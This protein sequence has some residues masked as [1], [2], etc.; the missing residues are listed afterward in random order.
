MKNGY[1]SRSNSVPN[2]YQDSASYHHHYQQQQQQA[3]YHP[4]ILIPNENSDGGFHYYKEP[5]SEFSN[6]NEATIDTYYQIIHPTLPILPTSK[7]QLK[8]WLASFE[9]KDLAGALLDALTG[10]TLKLSQNVIPSQQAFQLKSALLKSS[11]GNSNNNK[12]TS[13]ASPSPEDEVLLKTVASHQ[14]NLLQFIWTISSKYGG[15]MAENLRFNDKCCFMVL[16]I[17]LFLYTDDSMWLA[18]AISLGY[19]LELHHTY[20]NKNISEIDCRRLFLVLVILDC[21]NSFSNCNSSRQG[22]INFPTFIPESVI[23]F[24]QVRDATVFNLSSSS[25]NKNNQERNS[26]SSTSGGVYIIKLCMVYKHANSARNK[27]SSF[28]FASSTTTFSE[29][30]DGNNTGNKTT[31]EDS[32]KSCLQLLKSLLKELDLVKMEIEG[33]WDTTPILKALYY[34]VLVS[35][36]STE[37]SL[38]QA[39]RNEEEEESL[40]S[41]TSPSPSPAS[42][43]VTEFYNRSLKFINTLN[44]LITLMASPLISASP[45]VAYLYKLVAVNMIKLSSVMVTVP[46]RENNSTGHKYW[47]AFEMSNW[48][49]NLQSM[50]KLSLYS[51]D[52]NKDK[53]KNFSATNTTTNEESTN[54]QHEQ[55][56]LLSLASNISQTLK[57]LHHIGVVSICLV[58]HNEPLKQVIEANE[59][60]NRKI[61]LVSSFL[62]YSS[63]VTTS[64]SSNNNS[65]NKTPSPRSSAAQL[66]DENIPSPSTKRK[67]RSEE[68]TSTGGNSG[69]NGST[70]TNN[71]NAQQ[72][73]QRRNKKSKSPHSISHESSEEEIPFPL[74]VQSTS[75][76]SSTNGTNITKVE[77]NKSIH[78]YNNNNNAGSLAVAAASSILS[79]SK[80]IHHH[81]SSGDD[82]DYD[83]EN[84]N[85]H[86]TRA[87]SALESL[88]SIAGNVI[89]S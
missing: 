22:L 83:D 26:S 4:P 36:L 84:K 54:K 47:F 42:S 18:S 34:S 85:N 51:M 27:L 74:I 70:T 44:E 19:S 58:I 2:I 63:N 25:S 37:F 29:V 88:A 1:N 73:E 10:L 77:D 69:N 66:E 23:H 5:V 62:Q 39:P 52:S 64:I 20:T 56:L 3:T 79:F 67:R 31:K 68:S 71:N 13:G 35:V 75:S 21:V 76:S 46:A 72:N 50:S 33:I 53:V 65:N 82:E 28:N 45:L 48:N 81:H 61:E 15:M 49:E 59:E 86:K 8:N 14:N 57:Y 24:D 12:S 89:S 41:S 38:Y 87:P 40:S 9:S 55:Y 80:S 7:I 6:W 30:A 32:L 60:I 11:P 16:L 17:F 43:S 78:H